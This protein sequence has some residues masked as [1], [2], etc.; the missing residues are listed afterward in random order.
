MPGLRADKESPGGKLGC[1]DVGE[2]DTRREIEKGPRQGVL[3][4]NRRQDPVDRKIRDQSRGETGSRDSVDIGDR[5][6]DPMTTDKGQRAAPRHGGAVTADGK[7]RTVLER[8][9][10]DVG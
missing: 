7:D 3:G 5:V 4:E 2:P 1:G 10:D 6:A 9:G 8:V